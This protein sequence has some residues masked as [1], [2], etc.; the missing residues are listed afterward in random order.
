MS[1]GE[2]EGGSEKQTMLRVCRTLRVVGRH[3]RVWRR[4]V[5]ILDVRERAD[6]VTVGNRL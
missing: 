6:F 5:T 2:K 3:W 1:Q 4:T